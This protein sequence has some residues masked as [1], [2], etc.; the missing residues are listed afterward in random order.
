MGARAALLHAL[1]HPAHW[2]A[3]ILISGNPG[4]EDAAERY[5][6][7][8]SDHALAEKIL[9]DGVSDF[10]DAWQQ[11]PMIRSQ[12]NIRVDWRT[13]MLANRLQQTAAGLAQSVQQFGLASCPNL[14]PTL[15]QLS[16]PTLII[17]GE[18]DTKYSLIAQRMAQT[19]AQAK[20]VSIPRVGHMPHLEAPEATASAVRNFLSELF[21]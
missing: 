19:L 7:V 5:R 10:L 4:I 21:A 16:C 17:S 18:L 13:D 14:W 12:Q 6:R 20:W 15:A 9:N 2:K 1:A 8:V 11:T 3:V